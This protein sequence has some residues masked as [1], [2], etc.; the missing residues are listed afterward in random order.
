MLLKGLFA[1]AAGLHESSSVSLSTNA[2][3][4]LPVGFTQVAPFLSKEAMRAM[5]NSVQK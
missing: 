1:S 2:I 3:A 4:N 5:W